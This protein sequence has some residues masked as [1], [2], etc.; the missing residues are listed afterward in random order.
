MCRF[1]VVNNETKDFLQRKHSQLLDELSQ[2]EAKYDAD[3]GN[4]DSET[5]KVIT[6]RTELL[7]NLSALQAR[8]QMEIAEQKDK[9]AKDAVEAELA[10][11]KIALQ[12]K[13]NKGAFGM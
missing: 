7:E 5:K 9:E 11:N 10:K 6:F 8:K 3:V 2:W 12:K 1:S 4:I 13:W